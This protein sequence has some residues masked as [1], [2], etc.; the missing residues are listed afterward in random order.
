M[1][2]RW[3]C[4]VSS[5]TNIDSVISVFH[6]FFSI[7]PRMVATEFHSFRSI[8]GVANNLGVDHEQGACIDTF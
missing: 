1:V 5:D 2:T 4:F 7:A 6:F 8:D 3:R